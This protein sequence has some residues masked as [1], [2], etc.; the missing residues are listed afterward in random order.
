MDG[1]Q[2]KGYDQLYLI[3]TSAMDI[4]VTILSAWAKQYE[5]ESLHITISVYR[6]QPKGRKDK[7]SQTSLGVG[8]TYSQ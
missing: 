3:P 8:M 5:M 6:T 7:V 1:R 4:Q 2:G